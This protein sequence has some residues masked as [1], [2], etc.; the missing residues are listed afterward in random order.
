MLVNNKLLNFVNLGCRTKKIYFLIKISKK[1]KNKKALK[2][3]HSQ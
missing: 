3:L 2:M 1:T